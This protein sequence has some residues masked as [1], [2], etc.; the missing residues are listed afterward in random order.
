MGM[1][2]VQ[3]GT[4]NNL[5]DRTNNSGR[6]RNCNHRFVFE[7]SAIRDPRLKF[8]DVFFQKALQDIS[9]NGTIHF[10]PRQLQYLLDRRLNKPTAT[11]PIVLVILSLIFVILSIF[12]FPAEPVIGMIA[13]FLA[14]L[15]LSGAWKSAQERNN[16]RP[17]LITLP[18]V[19]EW[20]RRW[21]TINGNTILLLPPL[22]QPA[23]PRSMSP[24]VTA[25]SFDRAVICDRDEIAQFL[26]A[27]NFHFENN[28]AVL[29]INGYPEDIFSTV[30]DMLQRNPD[31]KVYAIHNAD[32][33]GVNLV[34]QLQTE[35]NWFRDRPIQIIDLGLSPAQVLKGKRFRV[36][37][38]SAQPIPRQA[39]QSLAPQALQWLEAGKIVELESLMPQ[40][41]LQV[42]NYGMTASQMS[43]DS[44]DGG[45]FLMTDTSSGGI[46]AVESFG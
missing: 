5:R 19:R 21:Q 23:Q 11:H 12:T 20:L 33:N 16:P 27:N 15:S 39:R 34:H 1:K 10:T 35:P 22:A 13:A 45:F 37:Q 36:I 9:N 43:G 18:E 32:A 44:G 6:C 41:L 7:P 30:M 3:C 17:E 38:S 4:D 14:A 28:C 29:S 25:Y 24:E 31:L 40:R 2:C 26:I 46:Y 42:L 8:T